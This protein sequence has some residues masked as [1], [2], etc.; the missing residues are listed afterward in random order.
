MSANTRLQLIAEDAITGLQLSFLERP[1]MIIPFGSGGGI[2]GES[3]LFPKL[4]SH[5]L[6][7]VC[8]LG[9]KKPH[10]NSIQEATKRKLLHV[11]VRD[12][13]ELEVPALP[14]LLCGSQVLVLWA[15][16]IRKSLQSGNGF[17]LGEQCNVREET[18]IVSQGE[19][20]LASEV[21]F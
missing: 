7:M 9:A 11:R 18:L 3:C 19:K 8:N 6:G 21:P 10:G 2:I 15:K 20:L 12:V 13:S 1:Q 5:A 4:A 17:S 14:N 16:N